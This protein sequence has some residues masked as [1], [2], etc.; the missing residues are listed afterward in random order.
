MVIE[1]FELPT[2]AINLLTKERTALAMGTIHQC[3]RHLKYEGNL[4]WFV[5][6][7]GSEPEHTRRVLDTVRYFLGK[8]SVPG[9]IG[10][11]W[12]AGLRKIFETTSYYIRLEDDM[13]LKADL[14]ITRYVKMMMT[15]P[16]IGMVRLGQM[17]PD[18]DLASEKFRID[19]HI[20]F[21]EDVLLRVEKTMPYCFSGHPAIIHKRFH[22]YYGYFP[23]EAMSAGDLEL[24]MDESVRSNTGPHVYFP[25]DLGRFGTWGAWD[26]KGTVKA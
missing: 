10:A 26:H 4:N 5:T 11:C 23:E 2:A 20:G 6:D 14:D 9:S 19:T 17:V 21:E 22:D 12:N 15:N 25:W 7:N 16:K 3:L 18:L 13:Q 24:A 1:R 8:V